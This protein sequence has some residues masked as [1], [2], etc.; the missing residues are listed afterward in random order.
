M[1]MKKDS[2]VHVHTTR[3]PEELKLR[4]LESFEQGNGYKKTA[5]LT[6]VNKYTVRDY[7]RRY[8]TGDMGWIRKDYPSDKGGA[9]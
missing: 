5:T 6:G 4:C 8:R 3:V 7:H 9:S 2:S 1:S